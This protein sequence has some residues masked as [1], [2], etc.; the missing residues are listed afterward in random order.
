MYDF[1][2]NVE[3]NNLIHKHMNK[4]IYNKYTDD[5]WDYMS[6]N[7]LNRE[8]EALNFVL[9]YFK[10]HS[11]SAID[12]ENNKDDFIKYVA[13]KIDRLIPL[14]CF[15]DANKKLTKR[16]NSL[17]T[18]RIFMVHGK[19]HFKYTQHLEYR[20]QQDFSKEK[21]YIKKTTVTNKQIDFLKKLCD[22]QGFLLINEQY[23]TKE[24]AKK[25]ISYLKGETD[26]E[27]LFFTFFLI[28]V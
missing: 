27:P 17:L 10:S 21:E 19:D 1:E 6:L 23:M 8:E 18:R 13:M 22:E 3:I 16:Y 15:M 7:I 2:S 14:F 4:I 11:Y 26:N 20:Y 25:I 9:Q 5:L 12:G 28:T 24:N